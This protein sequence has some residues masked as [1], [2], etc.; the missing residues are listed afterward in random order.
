MRVPVQA[1]LLTPTDI[2]RYS[3]Q[4]KVAQTAADGT[5]TPLLVNTHKLRNYDRSLLPHA[6]FEA[7]FERKRNGSAVEGQ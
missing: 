1:A 4:F 2:E 6:V 7:V 3:D 5:V